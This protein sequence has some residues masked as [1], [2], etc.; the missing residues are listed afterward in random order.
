M[1]SSLPTDP[2]GPIDLD[3]CARHLE[4]RCLDAYKQRLYQN[5]NINPSSCAYGSFDEFSPETKE[6]A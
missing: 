6:T 5:F 2:H 1:Y 3:P 4:P